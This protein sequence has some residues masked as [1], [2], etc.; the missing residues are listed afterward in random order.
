[1]KV[2]SDAELRPTTWDL[3]IAEAKQDQARVKKKLVAA[4]VDLDRIRYVVA[5]GVAYSSK[6]REAVAVCTPM[7]T[8][9]AP[10]DGNHLVAREPSGFPYVP[11]LFFY[12]EGP[13]I[14]SLLDS[15]PG[16]P[17]LAV[18]DSQGIAHP[19]GLGL[20]AHI[21]VLYG[22]PTIGMTRKLLHGRASPLAEEDGATSSIRDRSGT[23]IGLAVRF[24]ARCEP[25]YCS[26]GNMVNSSTL[27]A[28]C[29][30]VK[31]V[32]SCLPEALAIVHQRANT[33]ARSAGR[34]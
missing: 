29:K 2:T 28:Y 12:R 9:G 16:L 14:C 7:L 31:S 32:R 8:S 21:G 5:I 30:Q 22:I 27:L 4:S 34:I 11:G 18:F 33:L 20:A 23:E 1:M 17:Q 19:R 6:S 13:A 24:K 26:P 15:L 3:S 10:V 25:I